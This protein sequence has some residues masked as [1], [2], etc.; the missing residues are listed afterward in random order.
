MFIVKHKKFIVSF[1]ISFF[2]NIIILHIISG[3]ANDKIS[4]FYDYT[5]REWLNN[6]TIPENASVIN[7]WGILWDEITDKSIEILSG[8]SQYEL[9]KDNQYMLIQL[10]NFYKSAGEMFPDERKRAYY[11]QE[12]YPMIFGV[13]FSKITISNSKEE[14]I[15]RL[16]N[17]ITIAYRQKIENSNHIDKNNIGFFLQIIE[18]MQFIIGA[19]GISN[20]PKMPELFVDSLETNIQLSKEYQA[21]IISEKPNWESP[22]FETDC[23][24]NYETNTIKIYAGILFALHIS[25]ENTPPELFSTIGRTIAHE[26]THAF[27]RYENKFNKRDWKNIRNSLI[28]QYNHYSIQ[29]VYYINGKKTFQ[30]NFA[31]LGGLE[32]SFMALQLYLKDEYP[33]YSD[34]KINDAYREYFISYTEFWKE[35]ATSEFEISSLNRIHTPQKFRA[36]GPLYNQDEF[37]KVFNIDKNSE[38]YISENVRINIW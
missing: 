16:I 37:Y 25:D 23:R 27:D 2:F 33:Q 31:D 29:D 19:P 13:I 24:Y 38:Y 22:P 21:E 35:K 1:T 15:K 3:Q 18:D 30:E 10:Q 6:T 34:K 26:M 4:D 11:I 8:V 12:H 20:L 32:V 14:L 36:I 17:Y 28:N 7:N 5:N 9:D